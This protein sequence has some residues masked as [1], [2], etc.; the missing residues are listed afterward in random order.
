MGKCVVGEVQQSDIVTKLFVFLIDNN[1]NVIAY[2]EISY[3][4]YLDRSF[5]FVYDQ[6]SAKLINNEYFVRIDAYTIRILTSKIE[7]R[8]SWFY[9][10]DFSFLP[11]QRL[12]ID[13]VVSET[14]SAVLHRCP[15]KCGQHGQCYQYLNYPNKYYCRCE[16]GWSGRLCQVQYKCQCSSDSLCLGT[17]YNNN[18]SICICSLNKIGPLCYIPNNCKSDTCQ[19][20]G[21]CLT[22]NTKYKLNQY[23]CLCKHEYHGTYCDKIKSKI[24]ISFSNIHTEIPSSLLIH[25]IQSY[26][27]K[28]P[29]RTTLFKKITNLYQNNFIIYHTVLYHIAYIEFE[30]QYYLIALNYEHDY[31]N[32]STQVISDNRCPSVK[33]VFNSTVL[34]YDWLKRVKHYH[35][36]CQRN[37]QKRH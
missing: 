24:E 18:Q 31:K 34:S 21:T 13:L 25:F 29:K 22:I 35:Q 5:S 10:I 17:N 37:I 7:Y 26:V 9:L 30:Q 16:Q 12:A 19:N 8:T 14:N 2:N 20:G 23:K 33:E 3:E 28:Q 11:V 15:I 32:I 36:P 4:C 6:F 27:D 1:D